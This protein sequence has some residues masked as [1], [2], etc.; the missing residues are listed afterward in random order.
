MMIKLWY[1]ENI[2][3]DRRRYSIDDQEEA[4]K[5][6]WIMVQILNI[7][8]VHICK[9]EISTRRGVDEALPTK[10]NINLH[11]TGGMIEGLGKLITDIKGWSIRYSQFSVP[12]NGLWLSV[13]ADFIPEE[14]ESPTA[15]QTVEFMDKLMWFYKLVKH[16]ILTCKKCGGRSSFQPYQQSEKETETEYGKAYCH[17]CHEFRT[18]DIQMNKGG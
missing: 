16:T 15:E 6:A 2:V 9:M 5:A 3:R 18:I 12:S 1:P 14:A 10:L 4:M 8:S 7:K 17:S 11:I 13:S